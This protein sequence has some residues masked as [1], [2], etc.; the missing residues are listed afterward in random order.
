MRFFLVF[1]IFG[2]S[3]AAPGYFF[4]GPPAHQRF[5]LYNQ[6]PLQRQMTVQYQPQW[7]HQ[8][9]SMPDGGV[10]AFVTG[11]SGSSSTIFQPIPSFTE[12]SIAKAEGVTETPKIDHILAESEEDQEDFLEKRPR[13][14]PPTPETYFPATFG[15]ASGAAIAIANS[16]STG[17]GGSAVS[18]ATAYGNPM[19]KMKPRNVELSS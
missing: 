15:S 1:A 10:S 14:R 13:P 18:H 16:Y 3:F 8:I 2:I 19:E 4:H 9:S 12:E 5:L 11:N 17:K 6:E 7:M